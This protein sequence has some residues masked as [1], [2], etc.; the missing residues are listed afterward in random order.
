MFR[1]YID[2]KEYVY[3]FYFYSYLI[4]GVVTRVRSDGGPIRGTQRRDSV[5]IASCMIVTDSGRVAEKM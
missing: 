2:I 1:F 5:D 3:G 4:M